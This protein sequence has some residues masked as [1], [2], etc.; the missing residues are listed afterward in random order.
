MRRLFRCQREF[1][2]CALPSYFF[3]G[4]KLC[5]IDTGTMKNAEACVSPCGRFVAACGMSKPMNVNLWKTSYWS[6]N[7][8]FCRNE[9]DNKIINMYQTI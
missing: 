6:T 7:I 5:S 1:F 9:G 2:G 8:R 4:D 3:V